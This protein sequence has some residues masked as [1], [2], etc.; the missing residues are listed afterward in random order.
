MKKRIEMADIRAVRKALEKIQFRSIDNTSYIFLPIAGIQMV[1]DDMF[2]LVNKEKVNSNSGVSAGLSLRF[3]ESENKKDEGR[4]FLTSCLAY[5]D[6]SY[7]YE[8]DIITFAKLTD[9]KLSKNDIEV[10]SNLEC[11]LIKK[12][13]F[14]EFF[15][16]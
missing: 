8:F 1:E 2:Q 7:A 3:M 13:Q 11:Y 15:K 12:S 4:E 14:L 6:S 10:L 9:S 16:F 5:A